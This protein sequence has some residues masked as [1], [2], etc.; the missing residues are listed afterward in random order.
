MKRRF[1]PLTLAAAVGLAVLLWPAAGWAQAVTVTRYAEPAAWHE[2]LEIGPVAGLTTLWHQAPLASALPL[3]ATVQFR[4]WTPVGVAVTWAGAQ[5]VESGLNRSVA[6]HRFDTAGVHAVSA[7]YFD[8]RGERIE[9]R[10]VFEVIDTASHPVRV[11]AVELAVDPV[12]VDS[13]NPNA[14]TMGYYFRDESIAALRELAQG[15]YRTSVDRWLRLRATVEPVGFAPLVEWRANGTAQRRL[16]AEVEL[17]ALQPGSFQLLAGP[18]GGSRAVQL[19]T[20]RVKVTGPLASAEIEDGSPATFRAETVPPGL[21]DEV[22]WL[23]STKFGDCNPMLGQG[24]EFTVTFNGTF[25]GNRQWLGV[26]ADTDRFG[27]DHKGEASQGPPRF[28]VNPAITPPVAE[29]PGFDGATP[30]P[31]ASVRDE[32]GNQAEFVADELWLSSDDPAELAELLDRWQGEVLQSFDPAQFQLTGLARQY[33]VRVHRPSTDVGSLG[34]DLLALEPAGRGMHE[35]SSLDGLELLATGAQEAIAGRAVGVNWVGRGGRFRDQ[36]STEAST[37]DGIGSTPYSSNVFTWPTHRVGGAQDIGVA[38]AWRLLDLAG[39]L[40]NKVKL[41]ILD[42]G[43]EPNDDFPAGWL[44]ISNVPFVEPIGTE[45]LLSCGGGECPWHGTGV[46]SAAAAVADN[47]FGAAG[48]AGPVADPVL[49]YTSYDFFTSITALGE[50][51]LLG[52]KIANMS[53]QARVPLLLSWSVLPFEVAT[54]AFRATGMLL[55]AAAGNDGD[56]VDSSYCIRFIGCVEKAW[57]TPC[58]NDGVTCVGGLAWGSNDRDP[59][60]NYGSEE[61]D[62]FA[63]YTLWIGPDPDAPADHAR[64]GNGTSYASPFAAG[65]AALV[66]AGDP[67]LSAG[68]VEDILIDTAHDGS[69]DPKVRRWVDALAAVHEAVGNA[70]PAVAITAPVDASRRD[71]NVPIVLS[72]SAEDYED[73]RGCC[74]FTWASDLDG[75][76]GSGG[77]I[78]YTFLFTGTRRL[79]VTARDSGG[80]LSSAS[81]VIEIFNSAPVPVIDRPLPG[82]AIYR[83]VPFRLLGSARDRNEPGQNLACDGLVW[84]SSLA[85]DP[86]PLAGC[87]VTVTCSTTGS[88]TLTLTGT[89]PQGVMGSATVTVEVLEPPTNLPPAVLVTSPASGIFV[90]PDNPLSLTGVAVDPEGASPLTYRWTVTYPFDPASGT[91]PTT[92]EIGSE[93][94]V[95]WIPSDTI[96][97]PDCEIDMRVRLR[98]EATDPGGATGSDFVVVRVTRIC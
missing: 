56:N 23:A 55:F 83:G 65:V 19:D 82:E 16:G 20:Y 37:G 38:E 2:R 49:V 77:T 97:V 14:S 57:Y 88:R 5:Q 3:G 94:S 90:G 31:I 63:P 24:R 6:E 71:L 8:A 26:R 75:D 86:L 98:L 10:S 7:S 12:I 67:S 42:M 28:R 27:Q 13:A 34:D 33:L 4:L 1:L 48:P 66:W 84:R 62:I 22:T 47:G 35:V 69:S 89:D 9:R 41:A 53:Y 59:D 64:Q 73:G 29:L 68:Q 11:T 17:R 87:E 39:K 93:P 46:L 54:I 74:T 92:V 91:G 96:P 60:S 79:T 72:A 50:A 44:A 43:F 32:F 21:E 45:N 78:S 76:L 40:D 36:V 61:V 95:D 30:R 25:Q 80:A 70:P 52:A 51:R 85:S 15:H 81:V 18:A 58:E